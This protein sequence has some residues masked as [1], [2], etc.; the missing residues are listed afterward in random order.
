MADSPATLAILA[1]VGAG[2]DAHDRSG[3]TPLLAAAFYGCADALRWLIDAGADPRAVTSGGAAGAM[4]A[5]TETLPAGLSARDCAEEGKR[6]AAGDVLLDRYE[7][8]ISR[9]WALDN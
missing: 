5:E 8:V 6:R 1:R 3:L 4:G 9:L 7:A 2:L